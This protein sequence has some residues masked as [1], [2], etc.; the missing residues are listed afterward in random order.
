MNKT[1]LRE[2]LKLAVPLLALSL[3]VAHAVTVDVVIGYTPTAAATSGGATNMRLYLA[4][5]IAT[6]N[7]VHTNSIT[8]VQLK[9]V[10]TYQSVDNPGPT[11]GATMV[12]W[13]RGTSGNYYSDVRAYASA[14]GADIIG[15][16]GP[17][18]D[19]AGNGEQPGRYFIVDDN[20]VWWGCIGH[21]IGHNLNAS[22]EACVCFTGTNG[23]PYRT[24]MRHNYCGGTTIE[25]FSN[26]AVTYQG[27]VIGGGNNA[28]RIYNQRNISAGYASPVN[29]VSNGIYEIEPAHAAGKRLDVQG[30]ATANGSAVVIY[31]DHS[32]ANQR[33]KA[34]SHGSGIYS[35]QPQHATGSRLD[36]A[37][38]ASANGTLV[39]IHVSNGATAQQFKLLNKGNGEYELEPI[40]SPGKRL[41][42]AGAS[43]ANFARANLW[44]P[45]GLANQR[46]RFFQQ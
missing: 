32:G 8:D 2:L 30:A 29:L 22:H 1:T 37:N 3:P 18:N 38:G 5:S 11:W 12:G 9:L 19:T 41:D 46:F 15:L 23:A 26:P 17:T 44:D 27:V 14:A 45:L 39:N 6:S 21:E 20:Q 16:V 4:N 10:G 43:A 13:I 34:I 42:I 28:G 24:L 35:F 40:S 33:W 25:Y 7:V 36:V 31:D